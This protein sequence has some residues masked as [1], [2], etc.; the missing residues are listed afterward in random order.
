MKTEK[1]ASYEPDINLFEA[2][3]FPLLLMS[4][5]PLASFQIKVLKIPSSSPH[6]QVMRAARAGG[7][8][9]NIVWSQQTRTSP[10]PQPR[11]TRTLACWEVAFL[12]QA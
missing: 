11:Q 8:G 6:P 5:G 3:R 1:I 7:W 12:R 4:L 10:Y 9:Q 2:S